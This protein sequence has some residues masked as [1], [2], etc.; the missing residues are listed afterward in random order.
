[1]ATFAK[2]NPLQSAQQSAMQSIEQTKAKTRSAAQLAEEEFEKSEF[3]KGLREKSA[4]NKT[5]WA[6][7]LLRTPSIQLLLHC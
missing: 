2:G 7:N 3:L 5:K 6:V 1:M 4:E